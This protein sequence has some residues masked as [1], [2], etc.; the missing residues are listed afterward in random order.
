MTTINRVARCL[1]IDTAPFKLNINFQNGMILF[2]C[3]K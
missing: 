2:T 3:N 1:K